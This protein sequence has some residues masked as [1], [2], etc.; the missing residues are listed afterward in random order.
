MGLWGI[1]L[2]CGQVNKAIKNTKFCQLENS[3][4][5]MEF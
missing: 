4:T 2:A 3:I 1:T 5:F